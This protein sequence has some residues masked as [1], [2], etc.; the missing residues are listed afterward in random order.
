MK[1]SHSLGDMKTWNEQ[2]EYPNIA[3]FVCSGQGQ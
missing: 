3:I 1:A 2:G